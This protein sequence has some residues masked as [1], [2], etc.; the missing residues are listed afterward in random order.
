MN[1]VRYYRPSSLMDMVEHCLCTLIRGTILLALRKANT[2]ESGAS[3]HS[4]ME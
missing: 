1:L 4:Y 2:N 3:H